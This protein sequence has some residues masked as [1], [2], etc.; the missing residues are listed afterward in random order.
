[1]IKQS[2]NAVTMLLSCFKG[3]YQSAYVKGIAS[4]VVLTAG[5]A[6]GAANAAVTTWNGNVTV[7]DTNLLTVSGSIA[8]ATGIVT[9]VSGDGHTIG[10][11]NGATTIGPDADRADRKASLHIN[12]G[13]V[14]VKTGDGSDEATSVYLNE[15]TVGAG[16]TLA[17]TSSDDGSSAS[18]A[19]LVDAR[20]ITVSGSAD[21]AAKVTLSEGGTAG[22]DGT[23]T[24]GGEAS[25]ITLGTNSNVQLTGTESGD[26]TIKGATLNITGGNDAGSVQVAASKYGNIDVTN[27]TMTGGSIQNAGKLDISGSKVAITG[28]TLNNS[29][30]LTL[31]AD[32][33]IS[34]EAVLTNTGTI[35]IGERKTLTVDASDFVS[36]ALLHS[37]VTAKAVTFN[38]GST[39]K[40]VGNVDFTSQANDDILT[41]STFDTTGAST[42]AGTLYVTDTLSLGDGYGKANLTLQAGTLDVDGVAGVF[43]IGT[44]SAAGAIVVADDITMS[45][46]AAAP[47]KTQTITLGNSD[48][49]GTLTLGVDDVTD[50][51]QDHDLGALNFTTAGTGASKLTVAVGDWVT[52]GDVTV[53]GSGKFAVNGDAS[54]TGG[55]LTASNDNAAIVSVADGAE[56]TFDTV[57]VTAAANKKSVQIAGTLTV[58]GDEDVK[59]ASGVVT[60]AADSTVDLKSSNAGAIE[61]TSTGKIVVAD[62]TNVLG[63]KVNAAGTGFDIGSGYNAVTNNGTIVLQD[64][65]ELLAGSKL[66]SGLNAAA[67]NDL[68]SKL[69]G[70]TDA[71]VIDIGTAQLDFT[72]LKNDQ[73]DGSY[74]YTDVEFA[75]KIVNEQT[76]NMSVSVEATTTDVTGNWAYIANDAT[77]WAS[78]DSVEVGAGTLGLWNA[79]ADSGYLV[80]KKDATTGKRTVQGLELNAGSIVNLNGDGMIGKITTAAGQG[81]LNI[82]AAVN[83]VDAADNTKN[84]DVGA[85]GARLAEINV[86]GSLT[87]K[88]I[89]AYELN[90]DNG[91]VK[92]D[93]LI[94]GSTPNSSAHHVSDIDGGSVNV[95][96]FTVEGVTGTGSNAVTFKGGADVEVT[97]TF[98]AGA[99][100]QI[101]IGE[102]SD[103]ENAI[104][105]S[106]AFVF[107]KNADINGATIT[108]DPDYGDRTAVYAIESH[109]N[110]TTPD[111]I[112]DAKI[113]VGTNAAY[114]YGFADREE[115][116]DALSTY[117]RNGSLSEELGSVVILNKAITVDGTAGGISLS[118]IAT[119]GTTEEGST[120]LVDVAQAAANTIN[121]GKNSALIITRDAFDFS[122]T[123]T[124]A[125][126]FS[127]AAGGLQANGGKVILDGIFTAD[128]NGTNL[129]GFGG[130]TATLTLG[131]DQTS[132]AVEVG[133]GVIRQEVTANDIANNNVALDLQIDD[134]RLNALNASAAAKKLVRDSFEDYDAEEI[135]GNAG[136]SF[137]YLA[138]TGYGQ[139]GSA[140]DAAANLA[141]FGGAAQTALMASQTTTDVISARMGVGNVNS[142]LMYAD[143]AN[144]AG[145]WLAPV[146]RNHD[147]DSFDANGVDYGA[148]IDLTGVAFGADFTADEGLRF[149][150]MFNIGTGDADGQ[151]AASAVSNDFDYYALGLY[152]G[153]G[154]DKFSLVGDLT[155]AQSSND[156]G[157][158]S[159]IGKMNADTDVSALS[160]G[161]TGQYEFTTGV[162]DILPHVGVRFTQLEMDSYDVKVGGDAVAASDS[163]TM[164]I[165]SIPVGVTFA[166]EI[167]A[168]EWYVKPAL[169][170]AVTMNTGD[171]ELDTDTSFG[172][173]SMEPVSAEVID[174]VT[175]SVG[176]GLSARYNAL[177]LGLG[178]NY[179]GSDNADELGVNG[180]AR[181]S[182]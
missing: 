142:A 99:G 141:V 60:T 147:S 178:V 120:E 19:A 127:N 168:G 133:N 157:M 136:L 98:K 78:E 144:G 85:T 46:T 161:L 58:L 55:K 92:A 57:D 145:I 62:S 116:Q 115:V 170:L 29:S 76:R 88:D 171:N 79:Q 67:V 49:A 72:G 89:F 28:G 159:I 114:V 132:L 103:A 7:N 40:I 20:T 95:K 73:V 106:S 65:N 118:G 97:E 68:T 165:V 33:E 135:D 18:L 100:A 35:K 2:R 63:L 34:S 148:D 122:A 91:A 15:L 30:E 8:D 180:M 140:I 119:P 153:A 25:V 96:N 54:F 9:V 53:A 93:S 17:I 38:N 90:T 80:Y 105:S 167:A 1:M 64:M 41:G 117:Q 151:G 43:T 24:L 112:L 173:M 37:T 109:I 137:V 16:A 48:K 163:D 177:S 181:Y 176:L 121:L 14:T 143:N 74:K 45:T 42:T 4:A 52:A 104:P 149:G 164:N 150:A 87:A 81:T 69:M 101:Y 102:D 31:N 126:T 27:I 139:D 50:L 154:F 70:A 11:A 94:L 130:T 182:F 12:K 66:A 107:A 59:N 5:L 39:L 160:F 134:D 61:V 174:D 22:A 172:P 6:A 113:N 146:Y 83:V 156:I 10:S 123:N 138:G 155:Y 169:D 36:G 124:A 166:K 179:V 111:S 86:D 110:S 125:V 175:Y 71:G 23:S 47:A 131:A 82:N 44:S 75:N 129:L 152:A 21:S 77:T 32:T 162:L 13:T 51:T 56:A 158:N 128:D 84:A 26:T 108:I 3:I